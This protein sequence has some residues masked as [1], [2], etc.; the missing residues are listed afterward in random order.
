MEQQV[1]LCTKQ[2]NTL[3]DTPHS[4]A[5]QNMGTIKAT[6]N[7]T[8]AGLFTSEV[9]ISTQGVYDLAL[10]GWAK[11]MPPAQVKQVWSYLLS[12]MYPGYAFDII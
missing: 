8:E 2:G 6:S 3:T 7:L 11:A 9:T 1:L 10:R 4:P 12:E 5:E